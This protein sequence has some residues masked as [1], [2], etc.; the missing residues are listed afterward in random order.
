[1][2]TVPDGVFYNSL[3]NRGGKI[4]IVG[5]AESNNRV[6]SLMRQLDAS[7]W[8][9]DPNL[10]KVSNAPDFG[11]QASRF[12]LTVKVKAPK[13]DDEEDQG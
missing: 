13:S 6:S 5:V 1:M 8:L 2:R 3:T 11:D 9:A 10:D 12:N 4:S 7:D